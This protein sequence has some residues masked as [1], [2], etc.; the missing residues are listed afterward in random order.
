MSGGWAPLSDDFEG[1][2]E[3]A[4]EVGGE[5]FV[6]GYGLLDGF[7]GGGALVA[8]VGEGGEDV[9][10][11]CA[12]D[13]GLDG[14][15]GE[16]VELVFEFDDEAL[17]ELFANAGDADELGVVLAANGLDGALGG[18]AAEYLDGQLGAYAA[19]SDESLEEAFFLAIEEAEEGD[20]VFADL[21]VDVEG[22]FR[23]DAGE[24]GEGGDGDDHVIA[25]AS[26]FDD[27]LAGFLEDELAAEVSD[28][29]RAACRM[30]S[31]L[32]TRSNVSSA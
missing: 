4:V 1:T 28:H 23:T 14:G 31:R 6:F 18:E 13:S 15:Y 30:P 11:G 22:G 26:G 3:E 27:G 19:D 12:L 7:F 8:E 24:G 10:Y 16:V 17:G 25:D 21:G 2:A 29:A 20:L 9:V 32:A 5:G